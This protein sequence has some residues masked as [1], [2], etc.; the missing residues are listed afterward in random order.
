MGN[1][2][3][4]MSPHNCYKALGDAEKWVTIAVGSEAEWH[5]LCAVIGQPSL[6]DDPR[7]PHRRGCASATRPNWTG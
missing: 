7:F 2:D 3:P 5:A 4:L 1:H 6:A